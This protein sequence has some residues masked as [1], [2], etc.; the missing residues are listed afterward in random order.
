MIDS[1]LKQ[2]IIDHEQD[3]VHKLAL[4]ASR[5]KDVDIQFA[6]Q[7]IKG[8]QISK[9]KIPLWYANLN[10]VYSKHL[11]MEQCSSEHTA[12]FKATLCDG[13]S[14]VDLTGGFGVDIAFFSERFS[15]AYYVEQQKELTEIVETNFK[16]LGLNIEVRNTSSES[17]LESLEEIVDL[18]YIDPARR[19]DIGRK[20]V[21]IE[22]CTPNII[23]LQAQLEQKSKKTMIKLSPMLDISLALKSLKNISDVYI[24]SLQNECKELLFIKDNLETIDN[25][26]NTVKL[27][28]VNIYNGDK[29]PDILT[30]TRELEEQSE[31]NYTSELKQYLYE[32]NS[33]ILKAGA[34]K[35]LAKT[36]SV[37]KM[38]PNSH[39]YTSDTFIE[40]F[41]GR[42]FKIDAISSPDKKSLKKNYGEIKKANIA[43]RN[44]PMSP[45]EL[46]KK[47]N[48]KDGGDVYLFGTTMADEKKTLIIC[49]KL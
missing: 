21:S 7:Q 45:Q 16:T 28:C 18:I 35:V 30:Y 15:R 44:F 6:I 36:Y 38:H 10:V 39:L 34:Y 1:K 33:S 41:P 22:D 40:S 11:S 31:L 13:Q 37:L 49:H 46:G 19:D 9:I 24:I 29:E 43:T 48:I 26:D 3:N 12:R 2:F 42:I 27:H 47:L 14:I 4:Q 25:T 5:Y 23:E 20:T 32:P 8:R 17:Y